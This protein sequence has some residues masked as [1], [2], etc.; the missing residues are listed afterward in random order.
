M[1]VVQPNFLPFT[2]THRSLFTQTSLS[3]TN[4]DPGL[5]LRLPGAAARRPRPI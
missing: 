4:L 1:A 3:L 2:N 5:L